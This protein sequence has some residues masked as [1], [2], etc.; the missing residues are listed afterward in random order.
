MAL[1]ASDNFDRGTGLGANWTTIPNAT[2]M[3][4]ASNQLSCTGNYCGI[5]WN[6]D[7][8]PDDQ[9]SQIGNITTN[10]GGCCVRVQSGAANI[11]LYWLKNDGGVGKIMKVVNAAETQLGSDYSGTIANGS[12]SRLTIVGSVLTYAYN[13]VDKSPTQTDGAFTVGKAG[14]FQWGGSAPTLSDNWAGDAIVSTTPYGDNFQTYAQF[15][16]MAS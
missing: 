13:G 6:A 2:G 16:R 5:W 9:Y 3:T 11:N 1:P 8:W 12:T 15:Q 14:V 7:T 10:D 4:I